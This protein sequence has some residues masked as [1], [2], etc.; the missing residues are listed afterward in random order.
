M[1][2]TR[3]DA[4]YAGLRRAIIEQALAPGDKLPED[5]IGRSFGV[6][7]TLVRGALARLQAEGL[8]RLRANRGAE[9]ASPTLEEASDIFEMRR[10]LELEATRRLATRAQ[11]ADIA[12]LEAHLAEESAA[13]AGNDDRSIRLAGEFH[14]L[15]A[16]LAGNQ[17]LLGYVAELVSRCSLILALYGRPHSAECGI[18]EHAEIIEA[19]RHHDATTAATLMERH[20]GD[21]ASRA[22]LTDPTTRRHDISHILDRYAPPGA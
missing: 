11:P 3:A 20:L 4:V 14:I 21:V 6:S 10:C 12:R 1:Q 5:S 15:L 2:P 19:L 18:R 22:H 9:V 16:E 17:V 8:V 13:A 7:R